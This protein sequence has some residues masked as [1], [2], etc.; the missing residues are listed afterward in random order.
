MTYRPGRP[1]TGFACA[2]YPPVIGSRVRTTRP[3]AWPA[4]P[5]LPP[6]LDTRG[7]TGLQGEGLLDMIVSSDG[8]VGCSRTTKASEIGRSPGSRCT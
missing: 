5:V 8:P 6:S 4:P 2:R 3:P 1:P 7:G